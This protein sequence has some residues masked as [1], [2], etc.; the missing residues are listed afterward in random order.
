MYQKS[1]GGSLDN[2][3]KVSALSRVSTKL[4]GIYCPFSKKRRVF[5]PNKNMGVNA[6]I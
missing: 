6:F 4:L 3:G 1:S 2:A 5:R